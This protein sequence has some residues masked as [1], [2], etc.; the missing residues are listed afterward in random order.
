MSVMERAIAKHLVN[1]ILFD[2]S[3]ILYSFKPYEHYLTYAEA[4]EG[5]KK[6]MVQSSSSFKLLCS[7]IITMVL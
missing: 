2:R 5:L 4:I 7:W 1:R 3:R 6:N